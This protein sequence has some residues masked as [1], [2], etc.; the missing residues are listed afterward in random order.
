MGRV[1]LILFLVLI[2]L[3]AI[4]AQS[5]LEQGL[6]LHY[7]LDGSAIDYS[8]NNFD[9]I[10]NVNFTNDYMGNIISAAE[11]NGTSNFIDFPISSALKPELP[12]SIAFR[13]KFNTP[14]GTNTW[15][16]STNYS[17]NAY[18][19]VFV[20]TG[21]GRIAFSFGDGTIG[22]TSPSN[23]RT[24]TGTKPLNAGEWYY[25]VGVIRGATDMDIYVDCTNEGG[26]YSGSGGAL[27]YDTNPGSL[28]RGDVAGFEPY[29]LDGSLDDFRYWNRA[30]SEQ[31][32]AELCSLVASNINLENEHSGL[33]VYPNPFSNKFEVS[34]N[35]YTPRS[36]IKASISD[37]LGK[38]VL[39]NEFVPS[40]D[41]Q[42]V[43]F[44]LSAFEPGIYFIT[45]STANESLVRKIIKQ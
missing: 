35:N 9:G 16:L 45:L 15:V 40:L 23:R 30:L 18:N 36:L 20:N 42:H 24:K 14:I 1:S 3:S 44:D 11:F 34:W 4:N 12:I 29:F 21:N 39:Q 26:V 27:N 8:S 28:G 6:L 38:I 13:V 41:L 17:D 5:T 31:E 10:P 33:K 2:S 37:A 25:V 7:K 22:T 43:D 19:G 32:V